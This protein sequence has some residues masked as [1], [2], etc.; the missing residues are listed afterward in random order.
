MTWPKIECL[1]SSQGVGTCVM[2]NCEPFEFG[3]ELAI[4]RTPGPLCLRSLWNSSSND[5]AGAAGAGAFRAARLDHEV[6]D[7]AVECEAVVE[8]VFGELLEVGD[9]FGRFV[10]MQFEADI[11]VLGFDRGSFHL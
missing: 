11:A 1:L 2:K 3:P 6:G 4:E 8:A 9:R 10:V 7:D 5:V